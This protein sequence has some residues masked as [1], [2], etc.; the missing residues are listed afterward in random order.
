M[1]LH[2]EM[3][4]EKIEQ[5]TIQITTMQTDQGQ[6]QIKMNKIEK[7]QK[8]LEFRIK[9]KDDL[10]KKLRQELQDLT[11]KHERQQSELNQARDQI[12]LTKQKSQSVESRY[13]PNL[14]LLDYADPVSNSFSTINLR[15]RL[16]RAKVIPFKQAVLT[17]TQIPTDQSLHRK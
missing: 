6:Y 16:L 4:T 9:H 13:A 15:F 1:K 2:I 8:A 14:Q 3:L 5:Q 10:L 17:P 11:R 12:K 7:D